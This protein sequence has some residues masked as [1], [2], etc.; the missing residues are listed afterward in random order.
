[1]NEH[2]QQENTLE[3]W[4]FAITEIPNLVGRGNT[5]SERLGKHI[6]T[7]PPHSTNPETILFK[8][9]W[10]RM[11]HDTY[12]TLT[13][14]SD[15]STSYHERTFWNETEEIGID[16]TTYDSEDRKTHLELKWLAETIRS[17]RQET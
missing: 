4:N 5:Y 10:D 1:M 14:N 6:E 9:D 12:A 15:G 13:I 16:N 17:L 11:T 3:I 2:T 7:I 8:W